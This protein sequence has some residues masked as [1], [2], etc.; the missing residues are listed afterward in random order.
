MEKSL[1]EDELGLIKYL[2]SQV[3]IFTFCLFGFLTNP[4]DGQYFHCCQLGIPVYLQ[5][6]SLFV[7]KWCFSKCEIRYLWVPK[8]YILGHIHTK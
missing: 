6:L 7:Q 4:E 1:E 8:D 5:F 3:L 2:N